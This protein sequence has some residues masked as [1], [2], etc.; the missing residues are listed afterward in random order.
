[1]GRDQALQL[2]AEVSRQ[3]QHREQGG[4]P[5]LGIDGAC[6]ICHGSSDALAIANAL[7]VAGTLEA[8]QVNRQMITELTDATVKQV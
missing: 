6:I 8:R 3:Y 5:L 1:M 7:R 4:A 2:F